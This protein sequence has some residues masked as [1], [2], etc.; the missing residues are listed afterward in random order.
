MMTYEAVLK[1]YQVTFWDY[2]YKN[3]SVASPSCVSYIKMRNN[4]IGSQFSDKTELENIQVIAGMNFFM[5]FNLATIV[6]K[7]FGLWKLLLFGAKM[8]YMI[9]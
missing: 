2:L 5:Q 7:S 9:M 4:Y 8:N 1:T 3:S 6:M